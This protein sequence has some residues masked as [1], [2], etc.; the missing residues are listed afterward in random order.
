L[1]RSSAPFDREIPRTERTLSPSDYG[2]H[3][4]LRR[5]DGTL[6]FLDF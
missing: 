2:F 1:G 4:A 3:N 5:P 6:V